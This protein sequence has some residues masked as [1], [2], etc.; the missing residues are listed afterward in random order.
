MIE[1]PTTA[2]R[3]NEHDLNWPGRE[4]LTTL[5]HSHQAGDE[6]QPCTAGAHW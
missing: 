2:M 3:L 1:T 5:P 6:F 4:T